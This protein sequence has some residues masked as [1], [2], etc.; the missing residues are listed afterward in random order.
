MN[1]TI[2]KLRD[3]LNQ[4]RL[5]IHFF[6]RF[7]YGPS[8]RLIVSTYIRGRFFKPATDRYSLDAA[9]RWLMTAHDACNGN[10]IAAKYDLIK[11]WGV[12]YPETSGYI[13]TTLYTFGELNH[14]SELI[15]RALRIGDWEITIQ[16]KGGGVLSNPL[17]NYTRVFNT[18]QVI[19]GWCYLYE[20][21]GSSKYLQASLKA[22]DYILRNQ[23]TSGCWVKDTYCG[24]RTYHARVDWSLLRL[25]ILSQQERFVES[26]VR[27]LKW[28]LD[29]QNNEGWFSYCGFNEDLPNMHVIAYTLRGLLECHIL[30]KDLKIK[31]IADL[32][33]ISRLTKPADTLCN[34]AT[35]KPLLRIP[36][37]LP[38][39][40]DE[41]WNSKDKNSCLTGNA[42]FACFLYRLYQVT[43]NKN[44][45]DTADIILNALK[46]TQITA[47]DFPEIS[48]AIAGSYPI[49]S[50]YLNLAFPNWATKFFSDALIMK[51]YRKEVFTPPV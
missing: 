41:N 1:L 37:M 34:I 47:R 31:E 38:T 11:G 49:Y 42:Q 35:K 8:Q 29:Q 12:A 9:I 23:E 4:I 24:P 10:G 45:Q 22:A 13:L 5:P 43:G 18:G 17:Y 48:G 32:D 14:S 21:T 40:F 6:R 39:S 16:T 36:G 50:G 19:L 25:F 15:K 44:Y 30:N 2:Y 28:I 27:N 20:K 3:G 26:A 46:K 7:G 33:I 51:T